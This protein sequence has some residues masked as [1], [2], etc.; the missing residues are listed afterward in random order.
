[1]PRCRLLSPASTVSS[2]SPACCQPLHAAV[3]Q[4]WPGPSCYSR[5]S[6]LVG[7]GGP[8]ICIFN[9]LDNLCQA[10][11]AH[12]WPHLSAGLT[13]TAGDPA[14]PFLGPKPNK[15]WVSGW[16]LQVPHP[17]P[18]TPTPGLALLPASLSW[19][20]AIFVSLAQSFTGSSIASFRAALG[21]WSSHTAQLEVPRHH[22]L[23]SATS[24]VGRPCPWP[25]PERIP[26]C[27]LKD[28]GQVIDPVYAC[29]LVLEV[30]ECPEHR[31]V[32]GEALRRRWRPWRRVP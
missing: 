20:M 14:G 3:P 6:W 1:M 13:G 31:K 27:Q 18:R 25:L 32:R 16:V 19:L 24:Q 10:L 22:C 8:A 17:D 9:K 30:R 4:A 26:A 29:F 28:L 11:L 21:L 12:S 15:C 2:A 5:G 23:G 7:G